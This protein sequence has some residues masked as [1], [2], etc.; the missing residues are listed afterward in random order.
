MHAVYGDATDDKYT[1]ETQLHTHAQ[2][3]L[4]D[5]YC[6][7]DGRYSLVAHVSL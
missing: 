1:D 5:T 7:A 3:D 2:T 4:T 6:Q